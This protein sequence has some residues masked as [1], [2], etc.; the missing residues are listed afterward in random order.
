MKISVT[1]F[2]ILFSFFTGSL[3]LIAK[4]QEKIFDL[5]KV[6]HSQITI[7]SSLY[8]IFREGPTVL[9]FPGEAPFY[10]RSTYH[11]E[12]KEQDLG[13][14]SLHNPYEGS[15]RISFEPKDKGRRI[16]SALHVGGHWAFLDV[17]S[18]Q[19]LVWDDAF[20]AWQMP[21]DLILDIPR[22][23]RDRQGEPTRA[24]VATLRAELTKVLVKE[25]FNPDLIAGIT[26]IPRRWK[27]SDGSQFVL[28]LRVGRNPLMT[29]KCDLQNFKVCQV[30]RA[31]FVRGLKTSD[32]EAVNSLSLDPKAQ[33][34]LLLMRS[35]QKIVRLAGSSCLRLSAK[36]AY[37]LPKS[38]ENAQGIFVDDDNNFWLA[39]RESEGASSAS[40]FTW[41]AKSW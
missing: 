17:M 21:A 32:I 7:E 3:G 27:D 15:E 16:R 20:K 33:E 2:A 12:A 24:E 34:I 25:K 5:A 29:V 14:G 31:C 30:Q 38:L 23:P 37:T 6:K 4:N 22:P 18:R 39:L 19:F 26:A 35:R 8:G 11:P 13:F 41:D 40:V 28:W 36:D 10:L 1:I 9:S